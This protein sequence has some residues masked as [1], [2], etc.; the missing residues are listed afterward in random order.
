MYPKV[1]WE[2]ETGPLIAGEDT[3]MVLGKLML[4]NTGTEPAVGNMLT[5]RI[6]QD[7]YRLSSSLQERCISLC[8]C[9]LLKDP[10]SHKKFIYDSHSFPRS[11]VTTR[12]A[13]LKGVSIF[14]F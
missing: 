12:V 13:S 11:S 3:N 2:A 14:F 1:T 8:L 6:K 10:D 7:L 5:I 9:H 4:T